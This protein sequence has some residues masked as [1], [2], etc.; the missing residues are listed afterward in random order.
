MPAETIGS[1]TNKITVKETNMRSSKLIPLF[2]LSA[3]IAPLAILQGVAHVFALTP[4]PTLTPPITSPTITPTNTP[5][6]PITPPIITATPTPIPNRPPII[7]NSPFYFFRLRIPVFIKVKIIDRDN[8]QIKAKIEGD[9]IPGLVSQCL[10]G[11][12]QAY[13]TL[14]GTPTKTGIYRIIFIAVDEH[15]ARTVSKS[16]VVVT[17]NLHPLD[18]FDSQQ[19]QSKL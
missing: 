15:G 14:R 2:L 6:P 16:V 8:D 17:K 9:K 10:P 7:K 4:N 19:S 11:I 13:C 5:T 18:R 12:G 1:I 3:I